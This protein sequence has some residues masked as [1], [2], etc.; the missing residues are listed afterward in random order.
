M[1]GIHRTCDGS[2]A[3]EFRL[4]PWIDRMV[5]S[6]FGSQVCERFLEIARSPVGLEKRRDL[7]AHEGEHDIVDEADIRHG[8][9]DIEQNTARCAVRCL[10]WCG[11]RHDQGLGL[12]QW[13]N[14][15]FRIR[16]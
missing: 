3:A 4:S 10:S 1:H 6:A 2:I 5:R 14:V 16:A 7:S 11:I 8:P 9:F 13:L 12:D 15:V